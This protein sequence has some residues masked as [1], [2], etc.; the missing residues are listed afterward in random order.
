MNAFEAPRTSEDR[1]VDEDGV[2]DE[3][4]VVDEQE[5]HARIAWARISEPGEESTFAWVAEHG[6][7]EALRLLRSGVLGAGRVIAERAR[8]VDAGHELAV[9]ARLGAR[10][11]VAGDPEWPTGVDDLPQPPHA[12]W[13]RGSGDLGQLC[14]RSVSV[15]GAR[16]A[17]H[18]GLEL[19]KELAFGT[20]LRGFTVISG[21]AFGIDAAAHQGAL[22]A[23]GTTIAVL[24]CGID[25]VYPQAHRGLLGRIAAAGCVVTE[26]PPGSAPLRTRFLA[27]NRIIAAMSG[28]TCVVE[29]GLRSGSLNTAR[30]AA[31]LSRVIAAVPG[32]VT[33]TVSA[34][35]HRLVREHGA[36]LVTDTDELADA[37]GEIGRDTAVP[38]HTAYADEDWSPVDRLVYGW[39][40]VSRPTSGDAL[41]R[42]ADLA[43]PAVL[44]ALGR[45]EMAGAV[46]RTD[47]GWQ[48][49]P[50]PPAGV[51]SAND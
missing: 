14:R 48:K 22:A 18:Y 44:A 12:L 9:A 37:V 32:P 4:E 19:A 1:V 50:V 33:S 36:V 34:G 2:V 39:V 40:G 6:H 45:L 43:P 51:P 3:D 7:V 21:A 8:T 13:L 31:D 46:R 42:S 47:A 24:A 27:R 29:A 5:R 15:V 30:T 38:H 10:V 23:D 28:G 25:R 35:C 26:L 41:V 17:T 49:V 11:I 20:A 16:A